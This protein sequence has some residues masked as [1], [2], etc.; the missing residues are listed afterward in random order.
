LLTPETAKRLHDEYLNR[1]DVQAAW[2]DRS[3]VLHKVAV[4][5]IGAL[6]Y[7][8]GTSERKGPEFRA[9]AK[10]L[11]P[12]SPILSDELG[13]RIDWSDQFSR[14]EI[15]QAAIGWLDIRAAA[16]P[17]YQAVIHDKAHPDH[18]EAIAERQ[19]VYQE[20]FPLSPEEAARKAQPSIDAAQ[21]A[22]DKA[23]A[24]YDADAT[25]AA[26]LQAWADALTALAKAQDAAR[27]IPTAGRRWRPI[28]TP[29]GDRKPLP[30]AARSMPPLTRAGKPNR[31]SS[32][33]VPT[34]DLTQ[35]NRLRNPCDRSA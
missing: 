25:D 17:D 20:A 30:S 34:N 8:S 10:A 28:P 5:A 18:A 26:K 31:S 16:D 29:S 2:L 6:R 35:S 15:A 3:H 7:F 21:A 33:G 9:Q 19:E 22:V 32:K 11:M 24:E 12:L 14:E 1:P 4:S 27:A 23:K 13:V